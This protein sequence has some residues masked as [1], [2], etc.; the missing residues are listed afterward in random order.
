MIDYFEGTFSPELTADLL[1]LSKQLHRGPVDVALVQRVVL[2]VGRQP[3]ARFGRVSAATIICAITALGRKR[4]YC[5][6]SIPPLSSRML[7]RSSAG[8]RT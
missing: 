7:A 4:G 6:A 3:L 5:G 2:T 1:L 8:S